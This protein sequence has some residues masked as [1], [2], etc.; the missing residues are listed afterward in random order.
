MILAK[1]GLPLIVILF[2][3][4][5]ANALEIISLHNNWS[6][7]CAD[8]G[9]WRTAK[10]PGTVHQDL[11]RHALLPDPFYGTNE[12]RVQWV[13]DRDWEYRTRFELT[14][15]QLSYDAL[16]LV[17]EGLDTY[18]DVYLNGA[19][20]L[21][22]DNMFVGY[23]LDVKPVVRE[24]EN[25]L[26]VY[27]HS[28]IR[29]TIP[30]WESTGFS[31]PA[32]ND[33]HDKKLSV[34]TR[35]AP[36]SY[37]WD[38]GIRLVT[39][40]VW[41]PVSLRM[42]DVAS[43]VDVH[44]QQLSLTTENASLKN[45]IEL[46]NVTSETQHL[47]LELRYSLDGMV[48]AQYAMPLQVL[49]GDSKVDMLAEI[50]S[51]KRWMPRGWG[52][53]VLYQQDVVLLQNGREVSHYNQR[54]GLRTVRL[55]NEKD[56][57]GE[58]FYFE[59]NGQPL[60]AKGANYIPSDALL[61]SVTPERYLQLF[62]NI[63]EANMNM[64]R[65]WGGGVYEDNLFY[66]LADENGILVWQDFMFAC[67]TYPHDP[68]FLS[69]VGAEARYNIRRLRNHASLAIWCG[70]NEIMEGLRYWGWSRRFSEQAYQGMF[71][72]YDL[73]FRD[74]LPSMVAELDAGRSYVHGSPLSA[75]WGRPESWSKGDSHNW[76]VWYGQKPF[77]SFETDRG[78][79]LSEFGFQSFPEM[80]TIATFADSADY[81]IES[82]VMNAH[83]KSSIGNALIR[84]Y[85]ERDYLVPEHF[86][87]FVYVGLVLQGRG[88]RYGFEAQR[89][90]RPYCMGTLYWQLNDTW[91]VVSW[92][93]IDYYNN[94][95]AL[96]YQAANAFTPLL[97]SPLQRNDSLLVYVVNDYLH[98]YEKVTLELQW[99]TFQGKRMKTVR[100]VVDVPANN[101]TQVFSD[102]LGTGFT[103]QQRRE[104]FLLMQLKDR[105]G[106]VLTKDLHFF[107]RTKNL[108][109]PHPTIR[110]ELKML[111]DG[112]YQLSL[113]S[114]VLAKDVF[115][116]VPV[117]GTRFSDNF[118]DLL[119][120]ETKIVRIQLPAAIV[121][122]KE[123]IKINHIR[124]TYP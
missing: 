107:N 6:F 120:G 83:Q 7:R 46:R 36:Y 26:H 86:E 42:F 88:M 91:P 72:G 77:E 37:G 15:Q 20:L 62:E 102:A 69:R 23:A 114:P 100:K 60:F 27:F 92:S 119:P 4:L 121:L 111:S 99:I 113:R 118:F 54:I 66:E 123:E 97:I 67:T 1:L 104:S 18:A 79:F 24:G 39:S 115:V 109:L 89:R 28:P 61:P 5:S 51:P 73:L 8:D 106:K 85:M 76:G 35:K 87:D 33:H 64:I 74:L 98:S 52:D 41:R 122:N 55:V 58:S 31:Y 48:V 70:N 3:V 96:H 63:T 44:H 93:S 43:I 47:Q 30:Q 13:E 101:S 21:R 117:Q 116:E 103:D 84:T 40:G 25:I 112:A 38:W 90:H 57:W 95:K 105:R 17:F 68:L 9:E 75:N 2:N 45:T 53:P 78:R 59:V 50:R 65:V 110:T 82:E 56:E 34:Y 32:D 12:K 16:E 29:L 124:A 10:V 49:P 94:W 14:A 81:E 19:L 71:T 80:K 11:L 22:A 108:D